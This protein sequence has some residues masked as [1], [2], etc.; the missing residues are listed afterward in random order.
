MTKGPEALHHFQ[1][2]IVPDLLSE[3]PHAQLKVDDLS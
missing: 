3:R 1:P 2:V